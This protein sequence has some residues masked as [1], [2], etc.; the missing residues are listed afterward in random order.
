M[1][2][3]DPNAVQRHLDK[4]AETQRWAHHVADL[5]SGKLRT[6]PL[7]RPVA[8]LSRAK[9]L[10]R[11]GHSFDP[12]IFGGPSYDLTPNVPYRYSPR[13]YLVAYSPDIYSAFQSRIY[14]TPP[15][16]ETDP[17]RREIHFTLTVSPGLPCLVTLVLT[18]KG[19]PGMVGH[20]RIAS[21]SPSFTKTIAIDAY[22]AHIVDL[23]F[24][25]GHEFATIAMFLEP[26]IELLTFDSISVKTLPPP[27]SAG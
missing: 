6:Y 21:W 5:D 1:K 11:L 8:P 2:A 10:S 19:W 3:R 23:T 15:Q 18:G 27:L 25:P 9:R 13:A 16:R 4:L 26:G 24:V 17:V 20:V 14:W 12:S 7:D 22:V